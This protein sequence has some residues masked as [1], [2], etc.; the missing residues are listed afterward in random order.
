MNQDKKQILDL[1]LE[2]N[3]II[4][5]KLNQEKIPY[6]VQIVMDKLEYQIDMTYKNEKQRA[7]FS[8]MKDGKIHM[9]I[10]FTNATI[11]ENLRYTDFL[12]A[13]N[14]IRNILNLRTEHDIKLQSFI[15][16]YYK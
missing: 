16:K 6:I 2:G 4:I 14:S 1:I 9:Y 10:A 5:N 3:R 11:N 7:I 12:S 15:N 13:V 8:A